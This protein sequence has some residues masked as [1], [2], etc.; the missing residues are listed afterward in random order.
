M[1]NRLRRALRL[2]VGIYLACGVVCTIAA[3]QLSSGPSGFGAFAPGVSLQDRLIALF[4]YGVLPT[5][6]W[7][8][9]IVFL[10]ATAGR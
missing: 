1:N 7:P 10:I 9:W 8:G 4:F 6:L 3:G 5:L 2:A